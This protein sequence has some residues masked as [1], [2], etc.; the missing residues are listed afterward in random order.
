MRFPGFIGASYTLRSA[1]VDCQRCV[2]LFPEKNEMGRGKE[3]EPAS[4]VATPG[5]T[6]LLTL[7]GGATRGVY[8][9][10]DQQL[11]AVGGTK[12][13]SVSPTWVATELGTLNTSSGPVSFADNSTIVVIADGSDTSYAWNAGTSTFTVLDSTLGYQGADQVAY[14]DG[15]FL[16]N[17]P[18]TKQFYLLDTNEDVANLT[19]NGLDF[20]SKEGS[21]DNLIGLLAA[22]REA[23]LFGDISTEVWYDSGAAGF[24]LQR[25]EGA[26]LQI[27]ISARFSAARLDTKVFWLGK[28]GDG[29]GIV[30]MA[31]G[32]QPQR[33]STHA[34]ENAIQSYSYIGD[35]V[36]FTYQQD[37]HSFYVLNFPTA[38]TTWCFDATTGMWHERA[39]NN[40]G[41]LERHRANCHVYAFDIHI[42]GDY[43]TGKIYKLDVNARTDNGAPISRIRA[44][45]HLSAQGNRLFYSKFQLDIE[46][47]VG[48]DG[49]GQGVDPQVMMQF[50][51]DGGHKWSNERW[52]S[53]GAIG[54]TRKRAIWRRLGQSRDRVFRIVITDPVKVTIIGADL[55]T[56]A[57]AS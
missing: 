20:A 22:N 28:S 55:D 33:V 40:G 49:L 9:A 38:N 3:A 7:A 57:A 19:V 56:E 45:P 17:R 24:P 37:G 2:N 14:L 48:I 10:A 50:S 15:Y 29:A 34:V 1:N 47:G 5:L 53:F 12:F 36:G 11:Y 35:A 52:T 8:R 4:L 46:T 18:A 51:D 31:E 23:W 27:G 30:Y 41:T 32:V 42:V 16:F 13:Y 25:I 39:Y 43:A 6:L 26:F 54:A 44:A 21:P